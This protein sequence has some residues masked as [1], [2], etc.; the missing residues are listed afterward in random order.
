MTTYN[1]QHNSTITTLKH[2]TK[3]HNLNLTYTNTS[4]ITYL[5][6]LINLDEVFTIDE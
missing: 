6:N 1:K 3:V 4:Y 5:F 2:T